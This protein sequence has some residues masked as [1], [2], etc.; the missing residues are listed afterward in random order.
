M[1]AVAILTAL[2]GT[3]IS[4]LRAEFNIEAAL[5]DQHPFIRIDKEIRGEFGGRNTLIVAVIPK[6]GGDVWRPEIL[7]V[8]KE[9]TMK[10]LQLPHII[11][12]NVVSL[13]A[14]SVRHAEESGGSI[15]VDYLMRDV[16]QTPEEI[17]A[18][19][20]KL[21]DSPQLKG[22]LVTPDNKAALVMLDFWTGP[23]ASELAQQ[24]LAVVD[25]FK[26][27]GV[28]F[29]LAGEPMMSFLDVEQS[30]S[31]AT[32]IPI[33]F[34]VIGLILLISFR[35]LQG[36]MIPMLTGLLS[37]IWSLGLMGHTGIVID[38]WNVATPIL[39][40]AVA[41]GHSAQMLKR[42]AE[43]IV[44]LKDNLEACVVSTVAV[45]P[46]MIAAGLTAALGFASL[47]LF[48]VQS[49]ANFGLSCAYGIL[50]CV[51]LELTFIPALRAVLPAPKHVSSSGGVTD[52]L[53]SALS[54]GI[55]TNGGRSVTIA[56]CVLMAISFASW[57][58]L[59]TFGPTR[60]Y[61]PKDSIPRVHLE[62]IEEHFDGTV[63]MSVLYKG[64]GGSMKRLDVLQQMAGLQEMLEKEPAVV[65]T[66]SMADLVKELHKTF[67]A[68]DPKP[69]RLPDSQEL[70]SQLLFL[71][72]SP[73]FERFTDR[74]QSK[75]VLLAYL[76]DDDAAVIGP[77]LQRTQAWVDAHPIA[78]GKVEVLVAGGSGPTVVAIQEHTTYGKL[79]NML[80]V[81]AVIYGVASVL[82]RSPLV[83][84]YVIVPILVTI[85]ELV[86]VMA[87]TGM[88]LDMGTSSVVAMASGIGA[89]YAIYFLYRLREEHA[90]TP[91][92]AAAL[93]AA[94]H[95]SGRAV[96][97]VAASIG[98]GFAV[99]GFSPYL[100]LQIFGRLMPLSMVLSCLASLTIMPVLVLRTRPRFIFGDDPVALARPAAAH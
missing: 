65:R 55:L 44:R 90:R 19:R 85:V 33:T 52:K 60:E 91:D 39:L 43:E 46:V 92:D 41:S 64:D 38:S 56:T 26:D 27:R 36:M 81:M 73:A 47:A 24:T 14:P 5:P 62:K 58:F 86:G 10:G 82:M 35:N 53:L 69:Y 4:K 9:F 42:Y 80:M 88:K 16:P 93:D 11:G 25:E 15:A 32:R 97:F 84:F 2:V 61:M 59:R 72:D 70:V 13:A 17:A 50:S 79:V 87:W 3:G 6:D 8:V 74:S 40:I 23:P 71:G 76:R 99:L 78:G 98:A 22:M 1:A 68:D 67:N 7:A 83:G 31:V 20:K 54:E 95:A 29:Y 51:F 18:L 34:A 89:D 94:L 49:I 45:G 12:Q 28:S 75:S 21:D 77:L 96:L 57:P 37:T 100:G 63:T 66:A 48:G 30:K